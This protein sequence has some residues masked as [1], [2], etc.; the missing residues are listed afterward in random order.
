MAFPY[1]YKLIGVPK[2][3]KPYEYRVSLTPTK[4]RQLTMR[5]I[6]V[7]VGKNAGIGIGFSDEEY[8]KAGALVCS[9]KDVYSNSEVIVKVKEPQESE[10]DLVQIDQVL[11]GFFHF[12]SSE[13]LTNAMMKSKSVCIA[14]ETVKKADDSLPLLSPM[15]EIAGILSI[16]AGM[17]YLEKT[18]G[19]N[20]VLLS[21]MSNVMGGNVVII[22]GGIAGFSA[23]FIAS[24]IG[25]NVFILEKNEL[26]VNELRKFYKNL[27]NVTVIHTLTSHEMEKYLQIADLMI[28]AVHITGT[29]A[30]KVITK[31]MIEKFKPGSVF[32]DIA[33]D[34]GGM[35]EVSRPTSHDKPTFKYAN[36]TFYCV[37][38]I[39]SS[40]PMTASSA[41]CNVTYDYLE[42]IIKYGWDG[43]SMRDPSILSG[44]N[45]AAGKV[46]NKN[47]ANLFGYEYI[48][49]LRIVHMYKIFS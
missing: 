31:E 44:V 41:L 36:T 1:K 43:A 7:L 29:K 34:Q 11:F 42:K 3:V 25:A 37:P 6:D 17:K 19:G 24:K 23:S 33:I 38:N 12:A 46:T 10:Y 30:P 22:G 48:D 13:K 8:T 5:G 26:K 18:Y 14:Y 45:I 20:G 32:I 28:G 49:P 27:T 4:V 39:P 47:V 9:N 35:T 40:V 2:E 16:H 15:S 21:G